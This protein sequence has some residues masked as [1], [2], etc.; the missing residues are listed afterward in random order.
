MVLVLLYI[1]FNR[2][3]LKL[4]VALQVDALFLNSLVFFFCPCL[5]VVL[6]IF[7]LVLIKALLI[8]L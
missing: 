5:R 2:I 8:E 6:S 4:P 1:A 3:V 7:Q